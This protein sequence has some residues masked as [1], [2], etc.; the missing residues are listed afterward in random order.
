MQHKGRRTIV[1]KSNKDKEHS[2]LMEDS[3]LVFHIFIK[4]KVIQENSEGHFSVIR[5][6]INE[7]KECFIKKRETTLKNV[8][9]SEFEELTKLK[10]VTH[11]KAM[12][13]KPMIGENELVSS[14]I[15]ILK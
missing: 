6:R 15:E 2:D 8:I 12:E 4:L 7:Q 14:K 10:Y 1:Q 3:D 9:D 13:I 5:N 11:V